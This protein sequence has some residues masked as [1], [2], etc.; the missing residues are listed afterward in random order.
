MGLNA[1]VIERP[2]S[3][4]FHS[5]GLRIGPDPTEF[6][7]GNAWRCDYDSQTPK[8]FG[9]SQSFCTVLGPHFEGPEISKGANHV[10]VRPDKCR[11]HFI[12]CAP[13]LLWRKQQSGLHSPTNMPRTA[14]KPAA[15]PA[16]KKTAPK[17]AAP[18]KTIKKA[19]KAKSAKPGSLERHARSC[20]LLPGANITARRVINAPRRLGTDAADRVFLQPRRA[21]R[22][23]RLRARPRSKV[24]GAPTTSTPL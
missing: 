16:A 17:K 7:S 12:V 13:L 5:G 14:A 1:T 6:K 15:K 9:L 2:E 19:A 22:R 18:K 8:W 23:R 11:S 21:P 10:W 20:A 4:R 24:A 3:N